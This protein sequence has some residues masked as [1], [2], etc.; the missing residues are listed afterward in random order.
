MMA[1]TV[2]RILA[3][4]LVG[5]LLLLNGLAYAQTV[6]HSVHHAHHRAAT[7]ASVL[8]SWMCAAGQGLEGL[9]V[10]FQAYIGLLALALLSPWHKPF[11]LHLDFSTTRG[12]PCLSI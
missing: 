9:A 12:P 7:H 2:Q 11:T 4:G 1:R 8:C 5:C 6:E 10:V 3:W